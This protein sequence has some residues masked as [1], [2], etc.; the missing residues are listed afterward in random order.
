MGRA[1]GELDASRGLRPYIT[2]SR[3]TYMKPI[4]MIAL[5][6][7]A[8][9]AAAACAIYFSLYDIVIAKEVLFFGAFSF[10]IVITIMVTLP[11]ITLHRAERTTSPGVFAMAKK[12]AI[13]SS[14][15]ALVAVFPIAS[16]AL[17]F[18]I[19]AVPAIAT[20]IA[21][22]WLVL[23]GIEVDGIRWYCRRIN[24]ILDPQSFMKILAKNIVT[25]ARSEKF[26]V[27][28][29]DLDIMGTMISR[30]ITNGDVTATTTI[31]TMT[32]AVIDVVSLA[33]DSKNIPL[34]DRMP[35]LLSKTCGHLETAIA[36]STAKNL[37]VIAENGIHSIRALTMTTAYAYPPFATIPL[38]C[39]QRAIE[40]LVKEKSDNMLVAIACTM[41]ADDACNL[42]D[43][44]DSNDDAVATFY[45][46]VLG[47]LEYFINVTQ[48]QKDEALAKEIVKGVGVIANKLA[49]PPFSKKTRCQELLKRAQKII[50]KY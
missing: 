17:A 25:A 34:I 3:T 28:D 33:E 24:A 23:L 27:F 4:L 8:T 9:I 19:D 1:A 31:H 49:M 10:I 12:D 48:K 50:E 42:L 40:S 13:L 37:N 43:H 30:H 47:F 15:V 36:A 41:L 26:D 46:E 39:M 14:L 21:P 16:I 38:G 2:K 29:K 18:A 35:H 22:Y 45:D 11:L 20:A 44:V 5:Y 7:L 6:L 32:Q